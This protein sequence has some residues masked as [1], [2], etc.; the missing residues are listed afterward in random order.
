M[1]N[2]CFKGR[3]SSNIILLDVLKF[4]YLQEAWMWQ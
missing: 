3:K 4:I 1:Y 2:V